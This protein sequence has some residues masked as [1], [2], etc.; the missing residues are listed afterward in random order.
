MTRIFQKEQTKTDTSDAY[1]QLNMDF[2]RE[3]DHLI[4]DIFIK[5]LNDYILMLEEGTILTYQLVQEVK[6]Q[7]LLFISKNDEEK[8]NLNA[9]SL[10]YHIRYNQDNYPKTLHLLSIINEEIFSEYF[11]S[12]DD[13]FNLEN[14]KLL[15]KAIIYLIKDNNKYLKNIMPLFE[16][17]KDYEL[18]THSLHVAIYAINLGN[19]LNFDT[20]KLLHLGVASLLHD[21]GIKKIDS[22]IVTK[23]SSLSLDELEIIHHHSQYSVDIMKHNKISN[24]KILDAVLHHHENY[25]GTGYPNGFKVEN[26]SDF[27]A[28]ISIVDVF[29]ALTNSRPQRKA[30]RSFNALKIMLHGKNM[31]HK[32]NHSYIQEFLHTL[33]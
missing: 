2:I 32:F 29:D 31:R 4:F 25:D 3:G 14:I 24:E 13:L 1:I 19:A 33:E 16:S 15:V 5:K 9:V 28:I 20:H 8:Q 18:S 11:S 21:I 30:Y 22:D 23:N 17:P 27:S 26:I 6:R 10:K 12:D 7:A